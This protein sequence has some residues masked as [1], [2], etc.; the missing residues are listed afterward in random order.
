MGEAYPLFHPDFNRTIQVE[1]RDERLSSDAGLILLREVGER[2]GIFE[3]L[4]T[5][6]NDH[7]EPTRCEY[8]LVELLRTR[9]LGLA[10]GY[11]DQSDVAALRHDPAFRL[12][13]S[14]ARGEA[15]ARGANIASPHP[16]RPLSKSPGAS[17]V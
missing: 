11:D 1:A 7:R 15:P 5:H 9:L 17:V 14:S 2:L 3:W 4:A 13:T 12:A 8:S 10:A 16:S 6:L